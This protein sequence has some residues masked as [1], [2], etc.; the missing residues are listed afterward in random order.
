MLS[1]VYDLMVCKPHVAQAARYTPDEW[2]VYVAGYDEALIVVLRVLWG[3]AER[4]KLFART[5][6]LEAR[7]KR[8]VR[9]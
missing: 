1:S 8:Q 4:F 5:R 9:Q 2:R 6:R 3:A 7:R